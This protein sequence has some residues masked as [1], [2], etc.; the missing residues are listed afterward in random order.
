LHDTYVYAEAHD[1]SQSV[2][3]VV[4]VGERDETGAWVFEEPFKIFTT[5]EELLVCQGYNCHVEIQ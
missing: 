2:E 1:G 3:G 4:V 5:D